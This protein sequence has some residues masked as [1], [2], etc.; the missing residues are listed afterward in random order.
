[1]VENIAVDRDSAVELFTAAGETV[2]VLG[3]LRIR[4]EI[5]REIGV[6]EFPFLQLHLAGEGIGR[7]NLRFDALIE[8]GGVFD[9]V[10]DDFAGLD[11]DDGVL[12]EETAARPQ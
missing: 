6:A 5:R 8:E 3:L 7:S 2:E 12:A 4:R 10:V 1:M 9:Q 11:L